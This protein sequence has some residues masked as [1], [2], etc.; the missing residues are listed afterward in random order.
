M[1]NE[2]VWG[3]VGSG[4]G[5]Y[6]YLPA[7]AQCSSRKIYSIARY[8][9]IINSREDIIKYANRVLYVPDANAVISRCNA[10]VMALRPQDQEALVEE[11]L[12][13]NWSGVLILEKPIAR[14]P[15]MA[16]EMLMRLSKSGI[17]YRIGFTLG[18][19]TWFERMKEYLNQHSNETNNIEVEWRFLAHHYKNE[20]DTWKRFPIH[21]G[22]AT[23][24]FAIHII[25]LLANLSIDQP[26]RFQQEFSLGGDEP[27]C[28]FSVCSPQTKAEVICDSNWIGE[29]IFRIKISSSSGS[30]QLIALENP[31][32]EGKTNELMYPGFSR[33]ARVLYLCKILESL[34]DT[35]F[36]LTSYFRHVQLW[37]SLEEMSEVWS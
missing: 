27:K 31:F 5:L 35:N 11:I 7:I 1:R 29:P 3:I 6:G 34:D 13:E 18:V 33:D 28:K 14:T 32:S 25:S 23:R 15:A 37:G 21:G 2:R 19:T 9:N 24:F 26:V 17:N 8:E 16:R 36:D 12:V 22:G 20:I 4:F 10:V 30:S